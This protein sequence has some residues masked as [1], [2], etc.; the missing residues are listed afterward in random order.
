MIIRNIIPGIIAAFLILLS[1]GAQSPSHIFIPSNTGDLPDVKIALAANCQAGTAGAGFSSAT[2]NFT[3]VC[4]AGTNNL[5]GAQQ[6]IP[7]T[8]AAGQFDFELSGDWDTSAQPYINIFYGSGS[9][10]T[11]TVIWT[12]A[13]ACSKTNGSVTDDP[14]FV[15]ES[16]FASQTMAVANREWAQSGQFTHITSGNNCVPGSPVLVRLT[17]SGTA[18]SNINLYKAVITTPR[19][20]LVQAN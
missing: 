10:T 9:N 1:L 2:S 19:A 4:R 18:G 5:G 7:S 8:G 16:A 20:P 11:G 12:I 15:T 17:L 6:A 14:T 3:P 13:S